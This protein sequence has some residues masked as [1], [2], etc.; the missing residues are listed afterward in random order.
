MRHSVKATT[1]TGRTRRL[2]L[3]INGVFTQETVHNILM[4]SMKSTCMK[5]GRLTLWLVV[6]RLEPEAAACFLCLQT[7]Q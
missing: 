4:S 2:L 3:S 1:Q 5:S 6:L 7:F